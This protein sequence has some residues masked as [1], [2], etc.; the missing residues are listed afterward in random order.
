MAAAKMKD[1]QEKVV[2]SQ[3]GVFVHT[4]DNN[5]FVDWSPCQ[6]DADNYELQT[7]DCAEW[8]LI[9]Q[10]KQ[11][12]QDDE[13]KNQEKSKY[14]IHFNINELHSIRRSDPKLA[15][16]YVVFILKDS[17]TLPALHFHSGGIQNLIQNLQR[18]VWLTRSPTNYKLFVVAD[19]E[20]EA[21]R[22]SLDQLQLFNDRGPSSSYLSRF[23]N[24]AYYDG[25]DALSKVTKYFRD[26]MDVIQATPTVDT[27]A[28]R[29]AV[30]YTPRKDAEFEDL[31]EAVACPS[32]PVP[33]RRSLGP[34]PKVERGE[35]LTQEQWQSLLDNNGRVINIKKLHSTI[36]RGVGSFLIL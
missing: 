36:F 6:F 13:Q 29:P 20:N 34:V 15:W 4:S 25:M 27:P 14:A 8:D 9:T 11:S 5:T 18:Y 32:Q 3:D 16:S 23:I 24:T 7:S 10:N 12:D 1:P 17:T 33:P 22:M 19:Q 26:T 30:R 21:L 35:C 28:D 2:Y 31:G